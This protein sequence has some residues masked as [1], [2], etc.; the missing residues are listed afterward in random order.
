MRDAM[1]PVYAQAI[2]AAVGSCLEEREAETLS[3]LLARIIGGA[4]S[5]EPDSE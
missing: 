4:T 5:I 2:E 3:S 1:W